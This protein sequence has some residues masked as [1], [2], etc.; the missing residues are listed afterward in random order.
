MT[1]A[2][3]ENLRALHNAPEDRGNPLDAELCGAALVD[4][5]C[6]AF[7][8]SE[9]TGIEMLAWAD[10]HLTPAAPP[11]TEPAR[12]LVARVRNA[13]HVLIRYQDHQRDAKWL[14]IST[15]VMALVLGF[16]RAADA[17][18]QVDLAR[19]L[20]TSKQQ[21]GK[22]LNMFLEK[23]EMPPLDNQRGQ[24]ARDNM[25]AVRNKQLKRTNEN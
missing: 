14:R 13:F 12:E 5:F 11:A 2:Q 22:C 25:S 17:D 7:H 24:A 20:D 23:L 4:Q 8:V 19:K 9:A 21:V 6:A 18:N 16:N 15:R 1:E 3:L 10:D